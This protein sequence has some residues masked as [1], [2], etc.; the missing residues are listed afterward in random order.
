MELN[1]Y[2]TTLGVGAAMLVLGLLFAGKFIYWERA[3][4][5]F[6]RSQL[7]T[8]A[9]FG[10]ALVCFIWILA[11]L[12]EADFGEYKGWLM[13]LFGLIGLLSLYYVPDFLSVRG[14]SIL[15]LI[16]S[17]HALDTAYMQPEQARLW[18]VG[19]VYAWIV[20]CIVMGALP[21]LWR[22]LWNWVYAET[23]RVRLAGVFML[24]YGAWLI[25]VS[26]LYLRA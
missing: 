2:W 12:G 14:L 8:Y 21:Y 24:G 6:G 20:F 19:I 3:L 26:I 11:H 23:L 5:N 1:L 13:V 17:S 9:V 16:G 15:G 10:A 7:A 22:D 4:K 25:A 18:L